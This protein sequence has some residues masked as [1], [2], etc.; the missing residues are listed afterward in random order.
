MQRRPLRALAFLAALVLPA[1]ARAAVHLD[2][3]GEPAR[4]AD[5]FDDTDSA[6]AP[7]ACKPFVE[8][9]F[10]KR[11]DSSRKK[12]HR[13]D[14]VVVL[15]NGKL[16]YEGYRAP[17]K[18]EAPHALW[19]ASKSVTHALVGAAMMDGRLS[20]AP[21]TKDTQLATFFPRP[22]AAASYRTITMG[23]LL[24]MGAGFAWDESYEAGIRNSSVVRMYYGDGFLDTATFA[25]SHPMIPEGPNKKWTYSSGNSGLA[26]GVLRRA[27]KKATGTDAA[28]DTMPWTQLFDDLGMK[29]A[30][31]ERDGAGTFMGATY[32]H[33][34]PIDMAKLGQLYMD[35]GKWN[36]TRLLPEGWSQNASTMSES[37]RADP[38][39]VKSLR[40]DGVYGNGWWLNVE[41]KFKAQDPNEHR[42]YPRTPESMYG[43][44]GHYGQYIFI[45]PESGLVIARTG[46]DF[47][48]TLAKELDEF[49]VRAGSC[50]A[51]RGGDQ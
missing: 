49:F 34:R 48:F 44:F 32:V 6:R 7:N 31:I 45:F 39:K 15:K 23:H 17:W 3:E 5:Y 36:D 38:D 9:A 8:F 24:G 46:N 12:G 20:A 18:R 13:T 26:L 42:P 51:D 41:A 43:A 4:A 29:G 10:G 28:Y 11:G 14:G 33:M 27:Y 35:D 25:A 16:V 1:S 47:D 21:I 37:Y 19:S 50:F 30:T 2:A 40:D 22:D